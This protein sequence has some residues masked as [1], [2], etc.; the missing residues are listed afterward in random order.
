V[1]PERRSEIFRGGGFLTGERENRRGGRI[2][3]KGI[4][5]LGRD[6]QGCGSIYNEDRPHMHPLQLRRSFNRSWG[7]ES[8][9]VQSKMRGFARLSFGV[10]QHAATECLRCSVVAEQMPA[11]PVYEPVR[12]AWADLRECNGSAVWKDSADGHTAT[13]PICQRALEPPL[14]GPSNRPRSAAGVNV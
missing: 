11:D 9:M 5:G 7:N 3:M 6:R 4:R 2:W 14:I 8:V 12:D 13:P 10:H 1:R